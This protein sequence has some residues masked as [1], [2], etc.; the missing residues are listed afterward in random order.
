MADTSLDRLVGVIQSGTQT[1]W[2][3]RNKEAFQTLF[4]TPDG[5]YKKTA[6]KTWAVRAPEMSADSGVPFAAYIHADNPRSGPY[7]GMSLALFPIPGEPCLVSLI[8]GTQG[9]APD[10][11]ILGKPGHARKAQAICAWLNRDF[12]NGEQIAWAKQDPTRTDIPVPD[13]LRLKWSAYKEVF[14]RYGKEMYA[15]F[16]PV[17][18][19]RGTKEAITAFLDLLMAERGFEPNANCKA[20]AELIESRWYA[21]LMPRVEAADVDRILANRRFVI[22]QGP[23]G[24]GKDTD[25]D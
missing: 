6:E 2:A 16:R 18:E 14:D 9:L 24:T 23:P 19:A 3:D 21:H 12:G 1:A 22:I 7:S 4:G 20:G 8:V 25:G 15:L 13:D 11:A 10:E 5:R 17:P